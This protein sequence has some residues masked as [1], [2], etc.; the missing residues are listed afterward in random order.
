MPSYKS[1]GISSPFG[2]DSVGHH[3]WSDRGD[4]VV[5]HSKRRE[6]EGNYSTYHY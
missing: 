5:H 3:E 2:L 4:N 1:K 6:I